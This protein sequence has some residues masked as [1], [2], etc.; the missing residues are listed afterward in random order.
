MEEA[1]TS[2]SSFSRKLP[3]TVVGLSVLF[4]VALGL[5]VIITREVIYEGGHGLDNNLIAFLSQFSSDRVIPVMK[6]FT[7]FGS[8]RFLIPAYFVLIGYLFIKRQW[9]LGV[10]VA[11]VALTSTFLSRAAK[12]FFQRP[13]PDLPIIEALKTY[14]FPSGHAFS[15][16]ILSCVL[17]YLLW[18]SKLPALAKWILAIVCVLFSVMTGLSRVMLKMHYP[19][20]V[21]AGFCLGF[22]WVVTCFFALNAIS[23]RW[24][25]A[26]KA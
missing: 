1:K 21:L 11:I 23:S 2:E 6:F 10:H 5:F 18:R 19:T 17:V 8:G 12:L 7:F 16:F 22:V 25:A 4:I 15:T 3:F 13:R 9:M 24:S 20:D 26:N 14:S